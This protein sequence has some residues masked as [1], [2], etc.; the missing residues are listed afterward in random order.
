MYIGDKDNKFMKQI[1]FFKEVIRVYP[2][3]WSI[4]QS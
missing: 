1:V 3:I 4:S 2:K